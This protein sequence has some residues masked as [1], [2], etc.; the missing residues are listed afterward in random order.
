MWPSA[1]SATSSCS[2]VSGRSWTAFEMLAPTRRARAA[3]ASD[4]CGATGV[5]SDASTVLLPPLLKQPSGLVE[6]RVGYL[7]LARARDLPLASRRDDHDL[8]GARVE[9][10]VRPGDVVDDDRVEPLRMQLTTAICHRIFPVLGGESDQHL[11]AAPG[12]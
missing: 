3:N 10:D 1:S 9:P 11:S 5:R 4:S 6:D 7:V 2:S 8:V 12:G